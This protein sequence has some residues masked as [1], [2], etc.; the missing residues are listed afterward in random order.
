M[1]LQSG[2]EASQSFLWREQYR[3]ISIALLQKGS[4]TSPCFPVRGSEPCR[5]TEERATTARLVAAS[6]PRRHG[7]DRHGR[8]I[9]RGC[10][11]DLSRG[12]RRRCAGRIYS[13]A[14]SALRICAICIS[15]TRALQLPNHLRAST[16][17]TQTRDRLFGHNRC[18]SATFDNFWSQS[19]AIIVW[20]A[21]DLCNLGELLPCSCGRSFV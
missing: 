12:R 8:H 21:H 10:F 2:G 18:S 1:V 5:S 3:A 6:A 13:L 16:R 15:D 7:F 4:H 20:R 9:Q 11:L 14:A 19:L 17:S